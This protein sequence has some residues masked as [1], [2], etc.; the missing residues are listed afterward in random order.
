MSW[1]GLQGDGEIVYQFSR[2]ERHREVAHQLLEKGMAYKCYATQQ[3]LEEMRELARAEK[4]APRYDG[5]WR[6]RDPK[7]APAGVAPVIRIKAP[8]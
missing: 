2:A 7:D 5:R 4:R 8:R 3:E 6:D 1:L